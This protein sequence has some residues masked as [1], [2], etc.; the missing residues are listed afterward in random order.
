M[1]SVGIILLKYY[2]FLYVTISVILKKTNITELRYVPSH[3]NPADLLTKPDSTS[4]FEE[5]WWN[6]PS[7]L[8]KPE[9]NWPSTRVPT[10]EHEEI[11]QEDT[12]LTIQT[13]IQ[14]QTPFALQPEKFSSL[15]KLWRITAYVN[16]FLQK[17]RGPLQFWILLPLKIDGSLHPKLSLF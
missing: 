15:L 3:Q 1:F 6:G 7:F 9:E 4:S 17:K 10:L 5:I 12:T 11:P 14:P 8:C 13:L 16:K 2:P